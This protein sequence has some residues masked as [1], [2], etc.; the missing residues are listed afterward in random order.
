[1]LHA[2]IAIALAV[3]FFVALVAL[4]GAVVFIG[5]V[6]LAVREAFAAISDDLRA[7]RAAR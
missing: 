7:R 3:A 5:G 2:L 1:M 6:F 4:A